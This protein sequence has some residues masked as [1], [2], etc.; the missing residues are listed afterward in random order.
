[1]FRPLPRE[2]RLSAVLGILRKSSR[3]FLPIIRWKRCS[4]NIL[5]FLESDS[6]VP[7][8]VRIDEDHLGQSTF[9]RQNDVNLD[10][11]PNSQEDGSRHPCAMKVNDDG[12]AFTGQRLTKTPG[13]DPNLQVN[14]CASSGFTSAVVGGH[15]CY[16]PLHKLKS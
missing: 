3:A 7:G 16:L 12:F 9:I 2:A 5:W 13:L 11:H 4:P 6:T 15:L 8:P 1:M 10:S 14:P